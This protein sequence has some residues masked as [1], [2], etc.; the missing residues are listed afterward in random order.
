MRIFIVAAFLVPLAMASAR[1]ITCDG[2][3]PSS[4]ASK[5]LKSNKGVVTINGV[6]RFGFFSFR[7]GSCDLAPTAP[8]FRYHSDGNYIALYDCVQGESVYAGAS[9]VQCY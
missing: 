1:A 8:M 9:Y 2:V 7:H 4:S 3:A 5:R 6:A